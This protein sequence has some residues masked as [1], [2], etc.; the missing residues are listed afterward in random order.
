M[1]RQASC[2]GTVPGHHGIWSAQKLDAEW[3]AR[4][5]EAADGEWPEWPSEPVGALGIGSGFAAGG[6]LDGLTPGPDLAGFAENA[7]ADGLGTLSDDALVGVLRAWRRLASWAAAGEIAAVAELD[8]RRWA[9]VAAGADPHLAEHVGDELAASLTLTTR[10]AD[11]LLDIAC[12]LARLPLTRAALAAGQIDRARA[13][14]ISEGVSGLSD[15]HAAAVE[16]AVIGRAP[17]QTSGRLRAA[18]QRAVLAVDPAAAK[19][20][21]EE[22]RKDARVEVWDERCGTAALAGRDLPPADVLAAD[23]RIDAL[24]RQLKSAGR[25]E[26]L[27][28]LRAQVYLALLQGQPIGGYPPEEPSE[29]TEVDS[30]DDQYGS[31]APGPGGDGSGTF[32]ARPATAGMAAPGSVPCG[33]VPAGLAASGPASCGPVPAGLAASGPVPCGPVPAGVAA[34]GPVPC[35]PVPAGVAASGP[36]SCGPVPAGA[37]LVGSVNLTMPLASWLGGSSEPGEAAGFGPLPADDAR[38]LASLIAREP[39][40]N[41]CLTLTG[42]DGRAVAHG[43]ARAAPIAATQDGRP[44][45][46]PGSSQDGWPRG[47]PRSSRSGLAGREAA[48]TR[49]GPPDPW[50]LNV[51]IRPLTSG[52]CFHKRESKGY[53]PAPSLRHL[54]NIRH[55]TCG[56]PGCR[57]PAARC[58]QDHTIP[59]D[60]GGRTC[61]CNLACLCRRHH[62]AKQAQGWWLD[63]PEPGVLVWRL[64]HG[65]SYEVNPGRYPG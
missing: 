1:L 19:R 64:P 58:D 23:K 44:R 9:E 59:H 57:N 37:R 14:V 43:C 65:R 11:A 60:R 63:Q 36:A 56:F 7:W 45:G 31:A 50:A 32:P 17:G 26:S 8:R 35:G 29:G 49:A 22:A 34:P 13:L 4:A 18:T 28:E 55:R 46:E 30:R 47:E 53:Q 6:L 10:S 62:R 48:A 51:T 40:A 33:P 38:A 24:A 52:E 61:E 16:S 42:R 5:T 39:G 41:W 21:R 2:S 54:V 20:R 25:E 15:A 3:L 12:G 27:S